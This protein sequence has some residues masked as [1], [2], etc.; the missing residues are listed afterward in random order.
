MAVTQPQGTSNPNGLAKFGDLFGLAGDAL[1]AYS[2]GKQ[3][4]YGNQIA[5]EANPFAKYRPLYGEKLKK[6][7]DD[8]NAFEE[9][10]AFQFARDQGLEAVT[11][12]MNASG[13]SG[14]GNMATE[15]MNYASGLAHQYRG[16]EMDRLANLSGAGIAPSPLSSAV[17]AQGAAFDQGGQVLSDI[18]RLF[19]SQAGGEGGLL[20]GLFGG[21]DGDGEK[22]GLW[23]M[24]SGLFGRGG[25]GGLDPV[26][27]SGTIAKYG[28]AGAA[29]LSAAAGGTGAAGAGALTAAAGGATGAGAAGA[30]A[31][32]GAAGGGGGMMATLTAAAP[33][34][35]AAIA[36]GAVI[37]H[38][39]PDKSRYHDDIKFNS[40]G[41]VSLTTQ[42][43]DKGISSQQ[44]NEFYGPMLNEF[45]R[46]GDLTAAMAKMPQP[47]TPAQQFLADPKQM[48]QLFKGTGNPFRNISKKMGYG[49][50]PWSEGNKEIIPVLG[51]TR[52]GK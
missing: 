35:A 9:D 28:G 21:T 48:L 41:T 39:I 16:T 31:A 38:N 44:V 13:F 43:K 1:G 4:K 30:G 17:G 47:S 37:A 2:A 40:D 3:N 22:G 14:S 32:A 6:L 15:L 29:A 8:P 11:R 7:M 33:W 10:P 45:A 46:T 50:G 25:G 24:A 5:E 18:G 52:R 27:I 36:A 49:K 34:A 20:S 23:G 12:K 51:T 42:F 19:G 26:D